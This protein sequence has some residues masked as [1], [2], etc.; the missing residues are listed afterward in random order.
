MN[1]R[2]HGYQAGVMGNWGSFSGELEETVENMPH[3]SHLWKETGIFIYQLHQKLVV[4]CSSRVTTCNLNTCMT[5]GKV[6]KVSR[7]GNSECQV[8]MGETAQ[9]L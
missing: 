6:I 7:Y 4:S 3:L 5:T 2:R 8:C 9:G 1:G